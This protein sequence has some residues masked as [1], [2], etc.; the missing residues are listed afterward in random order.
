[1]ALTSG[2]R[3]DERQQITSR[4]R[5]RCHVSQGAISALQGPKQVGL[6]VVWNPSCVQQRRVGRVGQKPNERDNDVGRSE[7]F[8]TLILQ[9]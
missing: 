3:I 8:R 9:D 4:S 2:G 5:R 6:F 7:L 1:M